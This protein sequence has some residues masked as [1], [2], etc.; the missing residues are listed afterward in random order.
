MGLLALRLGVGSA[1][2]AHG[3][4]KLFGWFGGFGPDGTGQWMD[5]LASPGTVSATPSCPASPNSEG[6]RCWR[7]GWPPARPSAAV[8][9]NMVVASSTHVPNGFF[10]TNGGY[11]L[12][13]TF[14]VVGSSLALMGPGKF[15]LD[16]ATGNVLNRRWMA[17]LGM[18][19]T[20]AGAAYMIT[21]RQPP[22]PAPDEE[23]GRVTDRRR[24]RY[25]AAHRADR[26][27]VARHDTRPPP[28]EALGLGQVMARAPCLGSCRVLPGCAL[29]M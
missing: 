29:S 10:N 9:G 16:Q 7:W 15:S 3:A 2:A 6:A 11:E 14:A 20:I 22:E 1:V 24:R 28:A 19:S 26:S 17:I 5:S 25:S 18:L 4:Q 27:L 23:G 12:P 21:T 8:T 13:A